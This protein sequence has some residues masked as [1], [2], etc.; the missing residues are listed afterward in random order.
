MSDNS[1][2]RLFLER[3][4]NL[5]S[6]PNIYY[7]IKKEVSDPYSSINRIAEV[8]SADQ[9]LTTRLLRLANGAFF[10]FPRKIDDITDAVSLIGLQQVRDLALCTMVVEM[11]TGMPSHIL[12][13]NAFW[14]HSLGCGICAR[15]LASH[16]KEPNIER[17]FVAGLLHDLGRLVLITGDAAAARRIFETAQQQKKS[18]FM[19]EREV[20]QFDHADLGGLLLQNWQLP[21]SLIESTSYHHRP[22]QA[23]KFASDTAIIHTADIITHL[24]EMGSSGDKLAPTLHEDAWQKLSIKPAILESLVR[25]AD[26]QHREV[27][28]IMLGVRE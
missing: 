7:Q 21:E 9:G 25:E 1:Q 8:I 26:R 14:R 20:F 3:V 13:M 10:G 12:Q 17:F 5:P 18:V 27:V 19:I 2:A 4:K 28:N 24:L 15:I 11:F 6:P 23:N 22:H 16:M